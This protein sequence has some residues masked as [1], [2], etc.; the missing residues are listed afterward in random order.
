MHEQY[1]KTMGR[2]FA[3]SALVTAL[4]AH[5]VRGEQREMGQELRPGRRRPTKGGPVVSRCCLFPCHKGLRAPPGAN[6][7]QMDSPSGRRHFSSCMR[8]TAICRQRLR[9]GCRAR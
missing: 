4:A 1:A 2:P 6:G 8:S 3:K 5:I 7:E 9:D